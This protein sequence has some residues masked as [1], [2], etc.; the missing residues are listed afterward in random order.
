MSVAAHIWMLAAHAHGVALTVLMIAMTL[1]CAWC[2]VEA[3]GRPTTH[4]LQRLLLMS[5]AMAGVHTVMLL[6]MPGTDSGGHAH[7]HA[8]YDAAP[9]AIT[10]ASDHAQAMLM[11]IA[12]EFLVAGACALSLRRRHPPRALDLIPKNHPANTP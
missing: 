8:T 7:H 6:G 4:C 1:W 5:L 9:A 2:A 3:I 10:A 12:V 11:I